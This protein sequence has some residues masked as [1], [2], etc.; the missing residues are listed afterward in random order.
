MHTEHITTILDAL[1]SA[2]I[3][4][5]PSTL[6]K[7]H[8]QGIM[9]SVYSISSSVGTLII[10][11]ASF[12]PTQ[13]HFQP[14]AKLK[15]ISRFLRAIPNVPVAEVLFTL[16]LPHHYIVVQKLLPGTSA[17]EI[18]LENNVITIKWHEPKERY[19]KQVEDIVSA[20][21]SAPIEGF[22]TLIV[23][24]DALRGRYASWEAFLTTEI[25]FYIEGIAR[26]DAVQ[27]LPTDTLVP[28]CRV[29]LEKILPRICLLERGALVSCDI[30]NPSNILVEN[31]VITGIVDWEWAFVADPAWEFAYPNPFSSLTHY[32]S[33]FP[34]LQSEEARREFHNRTKIY[35]Y[36]LYIMWT[37]GT[38][39]DG[40]SVFLACRDRLKK[41]L[42]QI[43]G[44]F[45]ALGIA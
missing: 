7:H 26:A 29:F 42:E 27:Q 18:V 17:G 28:D 32:F 11:Y 12:S 33:H 37:Y 4:H 38:S 30:M 16:K 44:L 10:H 24:N 31:G 22:G 40:G 2:E 5:D 19:E 35:E 1:S 23:D 36:L 43:S 13:A 15:P 41:K 9:S 21:H 14:W 34:H 20:I 39:G 25:S 45:K 6:K 3:T 8:A